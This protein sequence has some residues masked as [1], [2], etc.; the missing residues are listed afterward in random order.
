MT[1]RILGCYLGTRGSRF[2]KTLVWILE[3]N[4]RDAA[5]MNVYHEKM[6]HVSVYKVHLV[7]LLFYLYVHN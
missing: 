5:N 1:N 7:L 6:R 2:T 3:I 4:V